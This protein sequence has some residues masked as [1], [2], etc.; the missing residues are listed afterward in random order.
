MYMYEPQGRQLSVCFLFG[1]G[2][3]STECLCESKC[4]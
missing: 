1:G 2:L 3:A 4:G